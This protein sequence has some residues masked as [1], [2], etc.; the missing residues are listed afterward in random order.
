MRVCGFALFLFSSMAVASEGAAL[1]LGTSYRFVDEM[2]R[3]TS[4]TLRDD[5]GVSHALQGWIPESKT[6]YWQWY[7]SQ[8]DLSADATAEPVPMTISTLQLGGIKTLSFASW[9]PYVGA[10]LGAAQITT[11]VARDTRWAFTL[12]G[13]ARWQLADHIAVLFEA[14]WLGVIFNQSTGLACDREQCRIAFDAGAWSQTEF[15][16]YAGV[17][18]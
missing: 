5:E 14:R 8:F 18:F 13:G 10:T 7:A 4:V 6:R 12:N 3:E 16:V 9:T 17:Q 2:S 15:G 11:D 1:W